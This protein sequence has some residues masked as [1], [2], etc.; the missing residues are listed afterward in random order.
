MARFSDL[1]PELVL[2]ILRYVD[3][4][5]LGPACILTKSISLLAAPILKEHRRLTKEFSAAFVDTLST[6]L[7]PDFF[8]KVLAKPQNAEYVRNLTLGIDKADQWDSNLMGGRSHLRKV[9]RSKK[10]YTQIIRTAIQ[11]IKQICTNETDVWLQ[12]F[13]HN[14]DDIVCS[15][16]I[17]YLPNLER[18]DMTY[19]TFIDAWRVPQMLT[20]M[21]RDTSASKYLCHLRYLKINFPSPSGKW[22]SSGYLKLV[23]AFLS[24]RSLAF[25]C[26]ENLRID[27]D[28]R[29]SQ[30]DLL[31]YES[32]VPEI[33][34][35][36]C[37]IGPKTLFEILEGTRCLSSFSYTSEYS[38]S[39]PES[40]SLDWYRLAVGLWR[41]ARH[42]LQKVVLKPFGTVHAKLCDFREFTSLREIEAEMALLFSD[43][44]LKAQTFPW[45]LP[46]S[47]QILRLRFRTM[48]RTERWSLQEIFLVEHIK[49]VIDI[50]LK[51][52]PVL[53]PLLTE[54]Q[55][56]TDWCDPAAFMGMTIFSGT[57][58]NCNLQGISLSLQVESE[59]SNEVA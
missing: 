9:R 32:A 38:P 40:E 33:Q 55:L 26:V 27:D 48:A 31:P 10:K 41:H 16:L 45:M 18:L 47:L 39:T 36:N 29:G 43:N 51:V 7:L 11:N 30:R 35:H 28:Q 6:T 1:P 8:A 56:F 15:L 34:F 42:S 5:N 50:I 21:I 3:A 37:R 49:D 12:A 57:R 22:A 14:P 13:E 25:C 44:L 53:L 46:A 19:Y 58:E 59:D 4:R 20:Q 23:T 24:L 2:N 17:V 52:K 54:I